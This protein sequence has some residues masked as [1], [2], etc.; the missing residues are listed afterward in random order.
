MCVCV[1]LF[2]GGGVMLV[3]GIFV[4]LMFCDFCF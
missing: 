3:L 4:L 2:V 1:V